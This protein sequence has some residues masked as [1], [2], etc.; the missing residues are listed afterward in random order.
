MDGVGAQRMLKLVKVKSGNKLNL[1][2][3]LIIVSLLSIDVKPD[4]K[5]LSLLIVFH[6][7][8]WIMK[9]F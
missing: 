9:G 2:L 4:N 8:V 1:L 3:R 7:Q 5:L 6:I